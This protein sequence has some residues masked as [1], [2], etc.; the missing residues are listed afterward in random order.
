MRPERAFAAHGCAVN[1]PV[2]V[3]NLTVTRVLELRE[4]TALPTIDLPK[5][6]QATAPALLACAFNALDAE[7]ADCLSYLALAIERAQTPADARVCSAIALVVLDLDS[8]TLSNIGAWIERFNQS[9]DAPLAHPL[10]QFWARLGD[11]VAHSYDDSVIDQTR[12]RASANGTLELF[13]ALDS[14]VSA[15]TQVVAGQ[16]LLNYAIDRG[17]T[18]L[19]DLIISVVTHPKLL[20]KAQPVTRARF[21]E[22]LGHVQFGRRKV[23]EAKDAWFRAQE[24][25]QKHELAAAGFNA[26]IGLVR[27]L[28]DERDYSAAEKLMEAFRFAGGPGRAYQVVRYKHLRARYSLLKK[29]YNAANVEIDEALALAD[30][31]GIPNTALHLY[32]QE[33]AQ[34]L[35][36]LGKGQQGEEL[37]NCADDLEVG[38]SGTAVKANALLMRALRLVANRPDEAHD[39]LAQGLELASSIGFTRFLRSIPEAAARICKLALESDIQPSFVKQAILERKLPAPVGT[40]EQW[41]WPLRIKAL[42]AL[43]VE[44]DEKPL[45]FPGRTQ[46]KP[47]E[48]LCYLATS[49]DMHAD[50]I[51]LCAALWSTEDTGKSQK[52]LETTVSRLRK[53]LGRDDLVRVAG[54]QV[55]LDTGAVWCDWAH[56]KF[57]AQ[58]LVSATATTDAHVRIDIESTT[59]SLLNCYRGQFLSGSE[60]TPWLLGRRDDAIQRFVAAAL[61]AKT[62]WT[63][64]GQ[65]YTVISFLES[66]LLHEPL[67]ESL[68]TSLMQHYAAY[69]QPADALRIYRFFRNQLSLR[70]GLKPSAA[71]ESLKASLLA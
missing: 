63:R 14:G 24:T 42:G 33:K 56:M 28:L 3:S 35:F 12:L 27:E 37:L 32:L 16:M 48:L 5:L 46:G 10:A 59:K 22:E 43:T 71:V 8:G 26:R 52:S 40:G 50:S 13:G 25:A 68:V 38:S 64:Q 18:A 23:A 49:A 7:S 34:V 2:D 31:I 29:N 9:K 69:Q 11:L 45:S 15:D 62:A 44:L 66:A 67:S 61:A 70:T 20:D 57:L 47:L 4:Q 39:A 1:Q 54:G 58:Q 21:L 30:R 60:E 53:L 36:C 55:S 19:V 41:P 6:D 65:S 17:E 51:S